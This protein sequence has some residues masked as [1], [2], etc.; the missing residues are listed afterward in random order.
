MKGSHAPA[1]RTLVRALLDREVHVSRGTHVLCACSGGPDSTAMLHVLA[2]LREACGLRLSAIGVDHGLREAAAAELE[3]ARA[4]ANACDVPFEVA[5]VDVGAG[6]NLMARARAAR[7]ATM[8]EARTRLGAAL[9]ATAHTADDRA[10]TVMLRILRGAGPRGLAVLPPLSGDLLRP[11][12]R[13]RRRDVDKHLSR[14]G[15]VAAKDPSNLDAR[16]LR[17]RV[18]H[19]VMPLLASLSPGVV[20]ALTGLADALAEPASAADPLAGLG[21]RQ[22]DVV[23]AALANGRSARV[24]IDDRKEVFVEGSE[25]H[26]VVTEVDAPR[27]RGQPGGKDALVASTVPRR[28]L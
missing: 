5:R 12:V 16:F 22:R 20:G 23:R 25:A 9:I 26:L 11:L 1:L 4:V 8:R 2:S 24:R 15:I 13:A 18:R 3:V 14:Y 17:V 19:E 10:E 21:R 28:K 6:S 27:M 7:Y